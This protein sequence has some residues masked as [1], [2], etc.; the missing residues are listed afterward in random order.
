LRVGDRR[1]LPFILVGT[2][3]QAVRAITVIT[4]GFPASDTLD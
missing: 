1:V 2:S 4:L 3:L